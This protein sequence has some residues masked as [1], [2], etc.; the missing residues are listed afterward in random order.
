MTVRDLCAV[1]PRPRGDDP[2]DDLVERY[3]EFVAARC[4]PNTVAATRS[5][6]GVFFSVIDKAPGEIR[7]P[8][9]SSSSPSS[10]GHVA[11]AG[12]CASPMGRPGCRP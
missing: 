4:R 12:W 6:L 10:D 11:T 8:M 3:I 1:E 7:R 2:A 5:D 9:C